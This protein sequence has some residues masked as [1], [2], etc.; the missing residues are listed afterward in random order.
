V[1]HKWDLVVEG[2]MLEVEQAEDSRA[3]FLVA[4]YRHIGNHMKLGVGYNF[5]DFSDD[6]TDLDYDSQGF[7]INVV[8][9]L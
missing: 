9:K 8:G 6:L 2:R 3:G 4:G 7:F 5:T 1:V